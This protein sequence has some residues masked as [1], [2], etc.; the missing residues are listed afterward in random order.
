MGVCVCV[1]VCVCMC[2]FMGGCACGCALKLMIVRA[3]KPHDF[4][5]N[6]PNSTVVF[7]GC[8]LN[9]PQPPF[10]VITYIFIVRMPRSD[11]LP[12]IYGKS[13]PRVVCVYTTPSSAP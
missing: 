6:R 5:I 12:Q 4:L 9:L 3:P 10:C 2:V 13:V 1:C 11:I 8:S 7:H